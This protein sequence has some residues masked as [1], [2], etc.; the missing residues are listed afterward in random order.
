MGIITKG[1]AT[2][3]FYCL[4]KLKLIVFDVCIS[5]EGLVTLLQDPD[6][7]VR[8]KAAEAMGRFH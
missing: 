7:V 4:G 2:R 8:V 6:P 1:E 3:S 5:S